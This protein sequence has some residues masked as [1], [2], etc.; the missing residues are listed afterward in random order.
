MGTAMMQRDSHNL[1]RLIQD[2]RVEIGLTQE[3]LA[4]RVHVSNKTISTWERGTRIPNSPSTFAR[5]VT[6]LQL[7]KTTH[8]YSVLRAEWK[9]RKTSTASVKAASD[10]DVVA[11][12]VTQ[13]HIDVPRQE[14]QFSPSSS[15]RL[16]HVRNAVAWGR[17]IRASQ[18]I[19]GLALL[20]A[21]TLGS[22]A[23]GRVHAFPRLFPGFVKST[24]VATTCESPRCAVYQ[25]QLS[26]IYQR[27]A[28][29]R[30]TYGIKDL[31]AHDFGRR[32][33]ITPASVSASILE[34]SG[35]RVFSDG[36]NHEHSFMVFKIN[37]RNAR[38]GR[39][40]TQVRWLRLDQYANGA[41]ATSSGRG[42]IP[43]WTHPSRC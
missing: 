23:V 8:E 18:V 30:Q 35:C 20:L 17:R 25:A 40:E 39:T 22:I 6:G 24:A 42:A 29:L 13:A 32:C 1:G 7:E 15:G 2:R 14:V 26:Q 10:E 43:A 19:L 33:A 9:S 27:N 38:S 28:S 16:G 11:Q 3:E 31:D 21:A 41:T 12:D 4:A 36:L 37:V 5:L 34:C